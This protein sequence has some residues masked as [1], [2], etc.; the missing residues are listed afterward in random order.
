MCVEAPE[1]ISQ[2]NDDEEA[3]DKTKAEV[4]QQTDTAE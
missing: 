4:K 2:S 1:S 3:D